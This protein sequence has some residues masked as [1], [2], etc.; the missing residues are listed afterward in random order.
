MFTIKDRRCLIPSGQLIIHHNTASVFI[1]LMERLAGSEILLVILSL[2]IIELI[3]WGWWFTMGCR[4]NWGRDWDSCLITR[5]RQR[6]A[7]LITGHRSVLW[8]WWG[9]QG[10]KLC[11]D[12]FCKVTA[13]AQLTLTSCQNDFLTFVRNE[14]NSQNWPSVSHNM[15]TVG[16]TINWFLTNMHSSEAFQRW[17]QLLVR[18]GLGSNWQSFCPSAP[19]ANHGVIVG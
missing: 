7:V 18:V 13:E 11:M 1:T 3:N 12:D 2:L 9:L 6:F 4:G 8:V 15:L 17:R 5:T 10:L 14:L 19:P 16:Q